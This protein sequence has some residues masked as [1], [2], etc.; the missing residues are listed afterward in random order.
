[1]LTAHLVLFGGPESHGG[2]GGVGD[3]HTGGV[4]VTSP[5][6]RAELAEDVLHTVLHIGLAEVA[7]LF[8]SPQVGP[9]QIERVETLAVRQHRVKQTESL[10]LLDKWSVST[11]ITIGQGD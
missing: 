4:T 2:D 8:A 3:L 5:Q 11:R 1:M 9:V 6:V 10:A 7:G